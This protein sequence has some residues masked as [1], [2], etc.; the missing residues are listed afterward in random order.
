M[1]HRQW[2]GIS[3]I[4][5]GLFSLL[6][7]ANGGS[8]FGVDHFKLWIEQ[9]ASRRGKSHLSSVLSEKELQSYNKSEY[10]KNEASYQDWKM[11]RNMFFPFFITVWFDVFS[12][13]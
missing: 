8:I 1:Q 6:S 11:F 3:A 13:Y 12:L 2:G 4:R 10:M 7:A 5:G 9:D